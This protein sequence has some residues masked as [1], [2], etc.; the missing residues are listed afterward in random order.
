MARMAR[1]EE[2]VEGDKEVV[3]VGG[4][5]NET[6]RRDTARCRGAEVALLW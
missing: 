1:E 4:A 3:V 2:G 5:W 6:W